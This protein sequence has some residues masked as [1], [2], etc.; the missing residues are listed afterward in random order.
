MSYCEVLN[1]SEGYRME[2]VDGMK[3][4]ESIPMKDPAKAQNKA[5]GTLLQICG[6]CNYRSQCGPQDS[7]YTRGGFLGINSNYH[8][9]IL[10]K[11]EEDLY[12]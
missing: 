5:K 3:Q 11:G 1:S 9:T 12:T 7:V 2:T 4:L 6:Q 10:V 8:P